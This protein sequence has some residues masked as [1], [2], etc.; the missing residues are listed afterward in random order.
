MEVMGEL[1]IGLFSEL[2]LPII[3]APLR[4]AFFM[5]TKSWKEIFDDTQ[6]YNAI[7]GLLMIIAGVLLAI[8]LS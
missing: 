7:V 6:N 3:G 4:W 1:I 8:Y 2:I 5:G